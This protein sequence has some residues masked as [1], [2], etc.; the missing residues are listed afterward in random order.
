MKKSFI[1]INI[2]LLFFFILYSCSS[3]EPIIRS[4]SNTAKSYP[5]A[6][7]QLWPFFEKFEAAAKQRGKT[8]NLATQQIK[9]T[10]EAIPSPN[11]GLCNR[12]TNNRT[13]I[14][15]QKFWVSRS[16]LSQ[17]L[18]VFHELGHCSLH[19]EHRD[20]QVGGICKS[21]MRSGNEGCLDNYTTSSRAAYLDEL[22]STLD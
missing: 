22:F 16:E 6:D 10:I 8:I 5:L 19:L 21:I 12:S 13:I 20:N 4:P 11:V 9:A 3:N 14:I 18:I 2:G 7:Q 1:C 15:D 17:E